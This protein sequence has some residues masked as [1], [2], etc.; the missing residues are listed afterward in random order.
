MG[1]NKLQQSRLDAG[2]C[3]RCGAERGEGSTSLNCADCAAKMRAHMRAFRERHPEKANSY[4]KEVRKAWREKRQAERQA[5][6]RCMRCGGERAGADGTLCPACQQ[7]QNGWSADFRQRER[8]KASGGRYEI[9]PWP[10]GAALPRLE[11]GRYNYRLGLTIPAVLTLKQILEHYRKNERA[12]G[13]VP[14]THQVSRLIRW[15]IHCWRH[16]PCPRRPEG[17]V[18]IVETVN[19][20]LDGPSLRIARWQAKE[21]FDGNLSAA[22]RAMIINSV[23]PTVIGATGGP[24][25]WTQE[26]W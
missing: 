5:A 21:H 3:L 10:M 19:I 20:T 12:A 15:A 26:P 16:L 8:N 24:K 2:V 4:N 1:Y 22:L 18:W 7:K 9:P 11:G 17:E 23:P 25:R 6:D 14:K 13:R